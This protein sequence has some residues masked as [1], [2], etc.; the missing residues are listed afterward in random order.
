M[1]FGIELELFSPITHSQLRTLLTEN[2]VE[3]HTS[4]WYD[5]SE[6]HGKW[7]VKFDGSLHDGP[8]THGTEI[9]SPILDSDKPKDFATIRKIC[10]LL[11]AAGCRVDHH[12]GFHVHVD[13]STLDLE[14]KKRAFLR[15][16]KFEAL[17]DR[18]MPTNRRNDVYY[19]KSGSRLVQGVNA[20]QTESALRQAS[21]DRYMRV[22]LCA[23][24][25][26]GTIEF[27]QHS[28]TI[29]SET[30]IRWVNFLTQFM[31]A[32]KS[33][34]TAENM[35]QGTRRRRAPRPAATPRVLSRGCEK[36]LN[37]MRTA[38]N[39]EMTLSALQTATGLAAS[40]VKSCISA[41]KI[42][43]GMNITPLANQRGVQDKWYRLGNPNDQPRAAV[44]PPAPATPA[45]EDSLWRGIDTDIKAFYHERAMELGGFTTGITID[46]R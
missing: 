41:L 8:C 28:G 38:Q 37:A 30:V 42:T 40:T 25:K 29:N 20:A 15:Y 16:T 19:A 32:S 44:V 9:V 22:N 27:R 5:S 2:E 33:E 4:E 18:C 1:K 26:Y 23:L 7:T 11:Q 13:A 34:P 17:I 3:V 10:K 31:E 45:F 6:P 46:R 24:Q 12:C 35:E 36:V 39:N 21:Y 14:A 43:H